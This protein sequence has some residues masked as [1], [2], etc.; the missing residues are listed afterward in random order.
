MLSSNFWHVYYL[1]RDPEKNNR[2]IQ[3]SISVEIDARYP[4]VPDNMETFVSV[5]ITE[6]YKNC[7][8]IRC[9]SDF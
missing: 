5:E 3:Q 8:K 1:K 9:T 7:K 4:G 6:L 2:V